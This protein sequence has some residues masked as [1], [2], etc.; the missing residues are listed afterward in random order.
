LKSGIG[1][2]EDTPAAKAGANNEMYVNKKGEESMALM[3]TLLL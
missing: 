2:K 1:G 3:P